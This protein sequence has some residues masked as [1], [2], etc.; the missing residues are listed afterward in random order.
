MILSQRFHLVHERCGLVWMAAVVRLATTIPP[1]GNGG[2]VSIF[3]RG[4]AFACRGFVTAA[5]SSSLREIGP[6]TVEVRRRIEVAAG[7][8]GR[9][10]DAVRLVAVSKRKSME[11]IREAYA[12]GIRHFG[13]NYLQELVEKS[14]LASQEPALADIRWHYIGSIQGTRKAKELVAKVPG[15]WMVE[16][17][18]NK[19]VA[20]SLQSAF[21][22][23]QG[24]IPGVISPMLPILLQVNTS[25]ENS[26][27]GLRD[28]TQV[29]ELADFIVVNCGHLR[30]SGLMTIG[31][32]HDPTFESFRKL[33]ELRSRLADHLS[34]PEAS[35][36]LSMGM[37][38]DFE[39]AVEM[40]STNVR[41]GTQIFGAR[42]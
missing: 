23:R 14:R 15:L 13:E 30:I 40:G 34:L 9:A 5:M 18:E 4:S 24:L 38:G 20:Q 2:V 17:V 26:K 41:V 11:H 16:S 7:R 37:S 27:S 6:R 35:L 33:V 10:P 39:K 28:D 3:P 31:A 22:N 21:S 25:M 8:S 19:E 32:I 12:A 42:D 29:F 1:A 36:E